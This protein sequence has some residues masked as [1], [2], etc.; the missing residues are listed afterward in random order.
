MKHSSLIALLFIA[1]LAVMAQTVIFSDGFVNGS[2]LNPTAASPGSITTSSTAYEIVSSKTATAST[3][4]S[5]YLTLSTS[6]TSSG[7]TEAQAQFTTAPVALT[8]AGQYIE[9][10]FTFKA[11]NNVFNL[12]AANGTGPYIGLFNSGGSAPTNAAFNGNLFWAG[13]LSNAT[14]SWAT[15]GAAKGWVGYVGDFLY[16][17]NTITSSSTISTRPAQIGTNNYNQELLFGYK[18]GATVATGPAVV[19]QPTLTVGS[20]YTMALQVTYV[21][22]TTLAITNILYNGAGIGGSVFSSGGYTASYGGT[23]TGATWLIN[24]FDSFS[25]GY[26]SGQ[27][28]VGTLLPITNITVI[29]TV[30]PPTGP[31]YTVT[32]G[33]VGCS[34]SVFPVGLSGSVTTNAYFLLTNG[35]F[36]G[37]VV[38]G[39]NSNNLAI[40]FGP[41]FTAA[42]YTVLASNT[43]SGSTGLMAGS[44]TISV[45]PGPCLSAPAVFTDNFNSGSTVNGTSTPGGITTAS[46]TSY[47]LASTKMAT[48]SLGSGHLKIGLAAST[49]GGYLEAQA[50]FAATPITLAT[51]GDY[52]TFTY[53]FTDSANLLAGGTG[54][55]IYA[56]LYNSGGSAPVA[57]SLAAAGLTSTAGSAYAA[58]NCS[59]WVGYVS[60]IAANGGTSQAYTRPSQNAGG[61]ASANQEL[62]GNGN[63]GGTYSNPVGVQLGTE[64]SGV[65]LTAGQQYTLSC[66]IALTAAGTLAI[67]NNLYDPN[68]NLIFSQTNT[69]A[70][71]NDLT[72]SFDSLC[73]GIVNIGTS[74]DPVMDINQITVSASLAGTPGPSFTVMGGGV[75]CPGDQFL[76]GL[77]GSV[78]ANNYLLYTNGVFDGQVISGLNSN[79]LAISFGPQSTVATYTVLATNTVTHNTGLMS[80]SASIS[81]EP[82]PVITTNPTPVWVAANYAAVYAVA[83]TG[84]GLGYQWFTNGTALA[85][86]GNVSGS[87]TATLTISPAT[88][89]VTAA[90][91]YYVVITNSCG[92]SV[93][94]TTNALTLDVPANLTWVGGNPNTSW[95][96]ATTANWNN[97][98]AAT[99]FNSGDNVTF[100][101]SSS[102]PVVKLVGNLDPT[103]INENASQSYTFIGP[104]S[105][106]GAG[107]LIMNGTGSLTISNANNYAGGTTIS[108]GVVVVKDT[109]QKALGTGTVTLAGGQLEVG[110]ASGASSVGIGNNI[111][112]AA[113][114]T[115]Q[116]DAAGTYTMNLLGSLTGSS[117]A[118]LTIYHYLS[119][120]STGDRVRLYG[121]FT[122]NSPIVLSTY[123]NSVDLAPYNANGVQVYNGG[124][125]GNGGR[126][127]PRGSAGEILNGTNTFNDSGVSGGTGTSGY[128]L[129]LSGSNLGLGTDSSPDFNEATFSGSSPAGLGNVGI[130]TTLGND[131]IYASGGAHT[132]ANKLIYTSATNTVTLTIGGSNNFT[133]SG[134]I[135]LNGA[136]FGT[137]SFSTNRTI[138]INNTALTTFSGVIDDASQNCGIIKTGTNPLY[139]DGINTYAGS[140]T[141]SS[142][143]LAGS[144]TIAGPVLVSSAGTISGGDP[145]AI[146]TLIINNNLTNGGNVFIRVNKSLSPAQSND[147]VSVNGVLTNSGSGTLT[148]SNLGP[149]LVAGDQFYVFS[150]A[151]SNGAAMNVTG[152]GF[153]WTNHLSLDGSII[154]G[155]AVVV[156]TDLSVGESGPSTVNPAASF[157]YNIAVSNLGPVSASSVV[158]TDSLP[159]GLVFVSASGGGVA[160]GG[161][162]NWSVGSMTSGQVSNLTLTVTAPLYGSITNSA[163]V[164]SATT[165]S[166]LANNTS[167]LVVTTVVPVTSQP[168]LTNSISGSNLVMQWPVDHTGWRLLQQTNHLS[169]GISSNTN[170]WGTVAGSATNNSANIPINPIAPADF[171]RL[172]YP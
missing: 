146:G 149:I 73:I 158:V 7:F 157:S 76:V 108:N 2:T 95:D 31:S 32:G 93:T 3:V 19:G 121:S 127:I 116:F 52:I 100:D 83:A 42:T 49:T 77:S 120:S 91:G 172:V 58:G 140:T 75:G 112:V 47:D 123:G 17:S 130:D 48:N 110:P 134:P 122:N 94:S 98:T 136:D 133:W 26:R 37:Q 148:V 81:I 97:G 167:L 22:A 29:D 54:S 113:S 46:S 171:F 45:V 10:Y 142:G 40:S 50:L 68:S 69:A 27:P 8:A 165:D 89:S 38:N 163:S 129:I 53:T 96:L 152:A 60:T 71:A 79:N 11:T 87:H 162:V 90:N 104:G 78:T 67:T 33:G 6:Q 166:N 57:G 15:N 170:D 14:N 144:G 88:N 168:H 64:T 132:I 109:N 111:N 145:G 55:A 44:V 151:V 9:V 103:S 1:P 153:T 159:A 25:V 115:L 82:A 126:I 92:L 118:T 39:L 61:T 150:E 23:V 124:I 138:Q 86:G 137:V 16:F 51:P 135:Q 154:A 5:G 28:S 4:G 119:S 72:Q 155:P 18:N 59:N 41:Q 102:Y 160:S 169:S 13:G 35:V 65:T 117:N 99:N 66:T 131:T 141:V 62:I 56:G 156:A 70:G 147:L 34:S 85:D 80:S 30:T 107:S 84:G 106:T 74:L 105:I 20:F 63:G 139:L 101:D 36:D 24:T 114:S 21:N 161:T 125:S 143:L 128:S 164:S 43:V 12:N